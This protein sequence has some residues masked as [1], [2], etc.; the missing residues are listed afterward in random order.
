LND[1]TYDAFLANDRTL[2]DPQVVAV[3]KGGRVRLR[4]INAG[5]TT[6]YTI[7]LGQLNAS[8]IAVDGHGV[9]PLAGRRFP[10]AVAQRLDIL[11]ELP[12]TGGSFPV[13]ALQEGTTARSGV[14][15]AS[16]GAQVA[17]LASKGTA[18]GPVVGLEL[19]R[20]LRPLAPLAPRKVDRRII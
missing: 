8:L 11:V 6:N 13:L 7:D 5:A 14:I 9:T 3:E 16:A 4:I 20:K 17:K 19:E 18:S 12:D 15:L 1:V 10:I 2:E